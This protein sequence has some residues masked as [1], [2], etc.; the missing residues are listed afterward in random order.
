MNYILT[1]RG[2]EEVL[3]KIMNVLQ[4]MHYLNF[5]KQSPI[6]ERFARGWFSRVSL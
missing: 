4:G 3:L 6:Q 5:I 1:Q 2:D